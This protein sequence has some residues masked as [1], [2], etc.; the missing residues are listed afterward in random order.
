[1][2]VELTWFKSSY[3][4]GDGEA[5]IEI[6]IAW[7]K[8]SYSGSEGEACVEVASCPDAIH[9]RDSKDTSRPH[10]SVSPGAWAEFVAYA[11]GTREAAG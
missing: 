2:N 8:S 5:C 11:R 7:R 4:G 6:A 3:S 1:M 9:V 10:F